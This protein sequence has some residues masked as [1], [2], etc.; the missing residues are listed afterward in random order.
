MSEELKLGDVEAALKRIRA[1]MHLTSIY[2]SMRLNQLLGHEVYFKAECAQRVGAFKAR[3][4]ANTLAWLKET[5]ALPKKVI[6]YSSGNHAQAVAWAA[7]HFGVA[8]EIFMPKDV[9]KVKL[10]ATP[11]YGAT[12]TLFETRQAA[13]EGAQV[14]IKAG[15]ARIP[16][17]DHDQVIS[18]QGTACLEAMDQ[19][20]GDIDAVFV[21]CGGGGLLSGTWIAAK[22]RRPSIKVFGGEPLAANDAARSV[23]EGH[24]IHLEKAP[25]TIADGVRTLA[26]SD[27]TFRY[28]K[29][30]DGIFEITEE[31]I[32]DWSQWLCHLLKLHLEPTAALGMAAA[33]A[34]L[35]KQDK[36]K[37]VLVILSGGNMDSATAKKVW[38]KDRLL[39]FPA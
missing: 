32:L 13:E 23:R 5:N 30:V 19:I 21:P 2:S 12:V 28:L 9:S 10:V 39:E 22:G 3:G 33:R 29:Q 24:I 34:W 18:G 31:E 20:S 7:R 26:I 8:A 36:Q 15:A 4:A 35:K 16:P 25:N 17:Y 37:K 14:A 38:E 11:N 27:R 1:M 6:A